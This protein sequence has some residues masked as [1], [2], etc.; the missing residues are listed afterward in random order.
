MNR[1]RRSTFLRSLIGDQAAR[2][3]SRTSGA[4]RAANLAS[5]TQTLSPIANRRYVAYRQ[6]RPYTGRSRYEVASR[7]NAGM[8]AGRFVGMAH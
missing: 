1:R 5:A 6:Q 8:A 2:N 3:F 7:R 4:R